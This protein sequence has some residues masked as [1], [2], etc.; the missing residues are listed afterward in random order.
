ME[1]KD[2]YFSFQEGQARMDAALNGIPDRVP[3]SAQIHQLVRKE[4]DIN[5]TEFYATPA[6]LPAGTLEVMEKY[7]IDFPYLDYDVYNIEAEGIGQAM[8]Y[9]D[10]M[11]PE[12]DR[13]K[14]LIRDQEDLAKIRTPDFKTQ[15]RFANVV[16]MFRQFERLIGA[17]TTV[18]ITAPFT[19]A[20]NIRGIEALLMDIYEAPD[21][22]R[23]LFDRITFELLVPWIEFLK[24]ELPRA[25]SICCS[26]A[27]SSLPIVNM[28]ILRQ[29]SIP[30]ILK[31]RKICGPEV[32]VPNW[33]GEHYLPNPEEM[34]DLKL[35]VCPDFLEGQD[36][37]VARIGPEVYKAYAQRQNVPLILGIGARFLSRSSVEQVVERVR[38]YVTVGGKDGRFALMLCN[39]ADDT[40]P[41]NILAAVETTRRF[42]RY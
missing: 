16:E 12:V 14:P 3:V 26:D 27:V 35:K 13:T 36:P 5:A 17:G 41:A 6:Y 21:F 8:I 31:L 39:L 11:M 15:G 37:D 24:S 30:Y 32:Y 18:G 28:E 7:G 1:F 29:W 38:H 34:L 2:Q 25:K 9:G 33:V 19:L 42:G 10:M 40:P 20:G 22:V 4:L 23:A